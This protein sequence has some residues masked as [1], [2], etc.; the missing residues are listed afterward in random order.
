MTFD[1]QQL[2]NRFR[3]HALLA[4]TFTGESLLARLVRDS[5]TAAPA[6]VCIPLSETALLEDPKKAGTALAAALAQAGLHERRCAV[7]LPPSWALSTSA[8]L[9]EVAPEDLRGYFELRA[10]REFSAADMRLAHSAW[11]LPGGQRRATLAA[12]PAKRVEAL[13]QCLAAAGLRL[14]CLTLALDNCLPPRPEP[15]LHLLARENAPADILLT[16]GGG[17]ALLRALA[18]SGD[19]SVLGRELRITL[20]RLPEP[21]RPLVRH[22]RLIGP[23]PEAVRAT[24]EAGGFE[25]I[26]EVPAEPGA[27]AVSAARQWLSGQPVPFDFVQP[28]PDRLPPQLRHLERFNTPRNRRLAASAAALLFLPLFLFLWRCHTESRLTAEWNGMK[29]T[30]G[31][32][33]TLQQKIRQLRPWYDPAPRKLQALRTLV[34]VFP[35]RGDL[36]TRSVALG[37]DKP[38]TGARNT[39]VSP[40]TV[41]VSVSGFARGDTALMALQDSLRKQPGVSTVQRKQTRGNNPIQFSL[42]FKW[43][44]QHD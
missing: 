23:H 8:D 1:F 2:K 38:D 11:T 30:V 20:G 26:L 27:A 22:A 3:P 29:T 10:E 34:T 12:L 36:W 18:A 40:D 31:E 16:A 9:P 44:P 4:L 6:N 13:E 21:L 33:E 37:G 42:I 43:Q 28:E 32:L 41:V 35:E 19:P 7:C 14:V 25:S 39:P 5:E 17:C 24:L 15:T